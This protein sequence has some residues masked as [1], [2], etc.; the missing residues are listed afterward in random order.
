[1]VTYLGFIRASG[2]LE[3]ANGFAR[4]ECVE[5][6]LFD[7]LAIGEMEVGP[8]DMDAILLRN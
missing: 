2:A 8:L 6:R 4:L 3:G 7:C 5:E 1:M